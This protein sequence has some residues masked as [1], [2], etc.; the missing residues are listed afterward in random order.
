[1][2]IICNLLRTFA[3]ELR[4]IT[5]LNNT[6]WFIMRYTLFYLLLAVVLTASAQNVPTLSLLKQD[7]TTQLIVDSKPF[8]ILGGELG[9]ST[10][11]SLEDLDDVF[12]KLQVMG[13][14]TVNE[15]LIRD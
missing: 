5:I 8:L 13:L 2:G 15:T 9:N 7:T 3:S 11:S 14:S 6:N 10:A 12:S 1:M 4:T